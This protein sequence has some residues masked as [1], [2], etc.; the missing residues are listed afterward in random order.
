M[1]CWESAL[2]F[3][4]SL[5]CKYTTCTWVFSILSGNLA[6]LPLS[7]GI[8]GIGGA[9]HWS[10]SIIIIMISSHPSCLASL[11]VHG[12]VLVFHHNDIM[13]YTSE[14]FQSCVFAGC[15]WPFS[16]L[17]ILRSGWIGLCDHDIM[18]CVLV[19]WAAPDKLDQS[20]IYICLMTLL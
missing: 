17:R 3:S 1:S 15:S 13:L 8:L 6:G 4:T 18:L 19:N 9:I 7:L 5:S 16:V 20:I 12:V 14:Q 2:L 11:S 10:Q